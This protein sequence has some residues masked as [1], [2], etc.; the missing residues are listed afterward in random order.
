MVLNHIHLYV[1]DLP[2]AVRWMEQVWDAKASFRNERMAVL[3][4]DN[5]TLIL[6]LAQLDTE[7][8]I[9][10]ASDDCSRDYTRVIEKGATGLEPPSPRPWGAVTA[11]IQ[12]PGKLKFEIEQGVK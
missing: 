10:F 11:Y 4:L 7:A 3:S 2:D 5:L 1:C 6:D 9:G 8:T 12:G